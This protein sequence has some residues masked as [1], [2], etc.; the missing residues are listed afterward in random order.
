MEASG[1]A[2]GFQ[3]VSDSVIQMEM[4]RTHVPAMIDMLVKNG[5]SVQ[6]V[7]PVRKLEDYFLNLV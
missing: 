1:L 2:D 4:D 6:S 3:K 5:I 7:V